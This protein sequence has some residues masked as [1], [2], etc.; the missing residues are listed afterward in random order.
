MLNETFKNLLVIILTIG[1]VYLYFQ[2]LPYLTYFI[3]VLLLGLLLYFFIEIF[4]Q[5]KTVRDCLDM[6]KTWAI[7]FRTFFFGK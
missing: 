3:S 1:I 2:L 4:N 5:R 6:C 7:N